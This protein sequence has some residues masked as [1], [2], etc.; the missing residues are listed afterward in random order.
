FPLV[1]NAAPT[2]QSFLANSAALATNDVYRLSVDGVWV[3]LNAP[4]TTSMQRG[5]SFWIHSTGP[6]NFG[7]TFSI[8]IERS[9]GL[10][11]GQ[12][13]TEQKVRIH[14]TSIG[15]TTITLQQ[16]PS[17]PPVS[18]DY[19]ALAGSIP[20]SYWTTNLAGGGMGWSNLPPSITQA[21][22]PPGGT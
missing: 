5:E 19:P 15:P 18:A 9:K 2:F 14:N 20:F 10:D 16:M 6:C 22:V 7:G 3:R 8:E 11:F 1:T 12:F 17:E 13:L 4:A 21:N